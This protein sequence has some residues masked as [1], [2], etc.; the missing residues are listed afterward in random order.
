MET[1]YETRLSRRGFITAAGATAAA[2]GASGALASGAA[3][4]GGKGGLRK[5]GRI[6]G[7][8]ISIQLY[9]LRD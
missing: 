4:H 9:T 7:D 8:R 1:E 5:H 2:V 3:A 6:P